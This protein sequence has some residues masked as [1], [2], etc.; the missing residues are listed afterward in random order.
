MS[1]PWKQQCTDFVQ[2]PPSA[3][4]YHRPLQLVG[5]AVPGH[6]GPHANARACATADCNAGPPAPFWKQ[7][8]RQRDKPL[9]GRHRSCLTPKRTC[10]RDI[11]RTS[12]GAGSSPSSEASL[13]P[14]ASEL[15]CQIL[16]DILGRRPCGQKNSQGPSCMWV[17]GSVARSACSKKRRADITAADMPHPCFLHYNQYRA[18]MLHA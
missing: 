3:G 1:A 2:Q 17:A 6:H 16:Q 10:V 11:D 9:F 4:G 7:R 18:G 15:R 12:S 8:Y 14:P 5:T 13:I